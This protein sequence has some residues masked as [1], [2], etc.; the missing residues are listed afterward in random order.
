[1]PSR[2]HYELQEEGLTMEHQ[3]DAFL[4][5]GGLRLYYQCW[6]PAQP[7]RAVVL[8]CHGLSDH[9]GRYPHLVERL[10]SA[11]YAVYAHDYRGHGRSEGVRLHVERFR[12]FA[13]DLKTFLDLVAA[14]HPDKPLVLFA[15]SLGATV[16][17]EYVLDHPGSVAG[18]ISSATALY[19]GEGFPKLMLWINEALSAVLPRLRLTKLPT[20]GVSRDA[21]WVQATL[22]DPLVYHGPGTTRL[23]AEI[24]H[25][26]KRLR[27]RLAGITLPLLVLQA[28]KD[29]LVDPRGSRLLYEQA[30]SAD[31]TYK[32]YA[33]AFH[34]VFNDL[35]ESREAFLGDVVAWLDAHSKACPQTLVA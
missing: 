17:L 2:A 8:I 30:A 10:A 25:T 26:L 9:G 5:S 12:L 21:A 16:A 24:L 11:G 34:E 32:V 23:G 35:P 14:R 4:G 28:E 31:K 19:A 6:L 20:E 18:L 7:P 13:E 22:H 15:H 29:I 33:G 27:P 3:E 1:M